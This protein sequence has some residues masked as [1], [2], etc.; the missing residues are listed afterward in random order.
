MRI[1]YFE[2]FAVGDQ[3]W[4]AEV[5]VDREEMLEY[6]RR[7]D[8]WPFHIDEEAAAATPFGGLIASAGYSI[9]LLYRSIRPLWNGPEQKWALQGAV[10]WYVQFHQPIR[11]GQ[12]MREKLTILETRRSSKAGRGF[13]KARQDL[14]NQV[15]E[16]AL[17]F[18]FT[19]IVATRP[20]STPA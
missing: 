10:D 18:E 16:F 19:F 3:A 2:D 17:T 15:H 11:P 20:E 8:P 6:A 1:L 12:R 7:N 5:V 13:V 14:F 9:C 4:G